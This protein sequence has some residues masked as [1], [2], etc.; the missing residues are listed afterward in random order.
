MK[1]LDLF[2]GEGLAAW[3]YWRSGRFSEIVG[4]DLNPQMKGRYAFDFILGDVQALTYDFLDQFD[5]IHASPPCQAYSYITP[6]QT[7]HARLVAATRLMLYASGKP[8]VIE[9]VQGQLRS[10]APTY[11]WMV[12]RW[13]CQWS[14]GA[15]ST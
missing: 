15:I 9:N 5:F 7:R 10:C 6:D 8:H 4:V 14:G 13:G 2:C 11:L 1:L 12:M 3:G